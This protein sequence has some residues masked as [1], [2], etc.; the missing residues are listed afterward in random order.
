MVDGL[1]L[2]LGFG[3]KVQFDCNF[4]FTPTGLVNFVRFSWLDV[5]DRCF[6]V[7]VNNILPADL[8]GIL[9]AQRVG[10][11]LMQLKLD[12]LTPIRNIRVI[13]ALH[14]HSPRM[15]VVGGGTFR[16]WVRL[17]IEGL[18]CCAVDEGSED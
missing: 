8:M 7:L 17:G 2:L 3:D 4:E 11:T 14:K 12:L 9:T 15:R 5:F 16:L 1:W 18:C 10:N 13:N 6:A